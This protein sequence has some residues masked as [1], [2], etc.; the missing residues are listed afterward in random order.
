M[1]SAPGCSTHEVFQCEANVGV[2]AVRRTRLLWGGEMV[3]CGSRGRQQLWQLPQTQVGAEAK[4]TAA[5]YPPFICNSKMRSSPPAPSP[6]LNRGKC[7]LK[8][9]QIW[10]SSLL[11]RIKSKILSPLNYFLYHSNTEVQELSGQ[12]CLARLLFQ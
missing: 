11:V 9:K 10:Y 5:A 7:S 12:A 3:R 6:M 1:L 2:G 4:A 8:I